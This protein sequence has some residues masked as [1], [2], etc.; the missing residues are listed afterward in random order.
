MG[1][2]GIDVPPREA[3]SFSLGLKEFISGLDEVT[4]VEDIEDF[5]W[6]GG[7]GGGS[8]TFDLGSSSVVLTSSELLLIVCITAPIATLF[9][10]T[11]TLQYS[12]W[13]PDTSLLL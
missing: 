9:A 2:P 3:G 11:L 8:P 12:G 1:I 13:S 5:L 6:G 10:L 7:G 4:D